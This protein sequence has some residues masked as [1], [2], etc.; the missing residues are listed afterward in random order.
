MSFYVLE[1]NM[2]ESLESLS[3]GFLTAPVEI[4]F[5]IYYEVLVKDAPINFG[6]ERCH[7]DAPLLRKPAGLS[8]AL[9]RV[10]KTV[11][12]EATRILYAENLF[13]FPDAYCFRQPE[14]DC[15][16][17]Y[18]A[19][20]YLTPFLQ[21][22]GVNARFLRHISFN[23]PKSFASRRPPVLQA[24]FIRVLE[25]LKETCTDL[26][27]VEIKSE[28]PNGLLP[29]ENIEQAGQ[30][31]QTLHDGGLKDIPSLEKVILVHPDH[32]KQEQVSASCEAL[33]QYA[34]SIKWTVQRK[35]TPPII[36][37]DTSYLAYI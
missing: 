26:R 15:F 24:A 12:R 10:N 5:R 22:I 4:R 34:P 35:K 36:H 17:F 21:Q 1:S 16:T 6:F 20:P 18:S 11:H 30:M 37:T 13:Q 23:F 27:T 31:L 33:R 7:L 3:S 25:L 19:V 28:T 8:S 32:P 9:L 14:G 29:L 2:S